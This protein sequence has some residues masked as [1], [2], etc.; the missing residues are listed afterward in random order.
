[1]GIDLYRV[2]VKSQTWKQ[3][4]HEIQ[5]RILRREKQTTQKRNNKKATDGDQAEMDVPEPPKPQGQKAA[6]AE[7]NEA[8]KAEQL[9]ENNCRCRW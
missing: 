4:H 1:M 3:A 7:E 8:K 6:K 9:A 5:E 2:P